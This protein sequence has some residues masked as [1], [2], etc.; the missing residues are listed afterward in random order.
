MKYFRKKIHKHILLGI[1]VLSIFF[2]FPAYAHLKWFVEPGQPTQAFT[3]NLVAYTSAWLLVGL[4]VALIGILLDKFYPKIS[5]TWEPKKI[6][7]YATAIIGILIGASLLINAS[8]GGLFSININDIGPIHVTLLMLEGFIGLSLIL[9]LAVRQASLLL[10]GLWLCVLYLSNTID[11]LENIWIVGAALFLFFRGR[12]VLRYTHEDIFYSYDITLSQAQAIS[13]LR[14]F[15]GINLIILGFSEK[16]MYLHL[17]LHFLQEHPW[18]FMAHFGVTWFTDELFVF[19]AGAVEIILGLFLVTGWVTRLTA[20]V[21]AGFF[22]TPPFFMG[23]EE[24]IGHIPHLAM[25]AAVLI[26]GKGASL[27]DVFSTL[28]RKWNARDSYSTPL[29]STKNT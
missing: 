12:T 11:V 14:V 20:V 1:S 9:G 26:F 10:I 23:P 7:P 27:S 16:I 4:A 8:Q 17:G 28:R 24:L 6:E 25:V 21:L 19:S 5:F 3:G 2:A 15:L 18:N 13:F 29:S 22:L